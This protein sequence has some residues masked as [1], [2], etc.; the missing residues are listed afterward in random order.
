MK[1]A[2]HDS[3]GLDNR[4]QVNLTKS[5]LR[6]NETFTHTTFIQPLLDQQRTA[7]LT[8]LRNGL[9]TAGVAATALFGGVAPALAADVDFTFEMPATGTAP[10]DAND[11]P[12]NDSSQTNN[13]VRTLD[14]ITYRWK[15]TVNNGSSDNS[16][17]TTTL[18][19]NQAFEQIPAACQPGSVSTDPVSNQQTLTCNLGDIASGTTGFIDFQVKVLTQ[20]LDGTSYV[21]NGDTTSA[22][23]TF[24]SDTAAPATDG[25]LSAIV[26]AAP[27]VDLLKNAAWVSGTKIDPATG[28]NGAIVRYPISM[29]ISN[30]GKGSEALLSPISFIDDL[31]QHVPGTK[32]YDWGNHS[33]CGPLGKPMFYG[34]RPY[35]VNDGTYLPERSVQDSGT[36]NCTQAAAGSN[37]NVSISGADTTGNHAP[38][39]SYNNVT[40]PASQTWLVSGFMELWMPTQAIIDAGGSIGVTNTVTALN[41]TGVSGNPNQEPTLANNSY[42]HTVLAG[43]GSFNQYYALRYQNRGTV[44]PGMSTLNGGDGPVMATQ[45]FAKRLYGFNRGLLAWDDYMYCEKFDNETHKLVDI[46][47]QAG[48]AV[49]VYNNIAYDYVIEYGTGGYIDETDQ[50]TTTC[51]D[52]ESPAGWFD[53]L[54]NV[55][56]GRDA[57][58]KIR[59]RAL[60]PVPPN[61]TM[62][63]AVNFESRNNFLTSGTPIPVGTILS[64]HSAIRTPTLYSNTT[65]FPGNWNRGTYN[66]AT[67]GGSKS[68]GDRLTF[69][70][71]IVRIDKTTVP[72]DEVN[73]ILAGGTVTYQLQP[74]VTAVINPAPVNPVV[75]VT[76]ILPAG[77]IYVVGSASLPPT[78]ITSNSDGTTTIEWNLGPQVPGQVVTP[79]T[80]DAQVSPI[81]SNNT[82]LVNEVIVSSPE[83]PSPESA[84][85]DDRTVTVGNPG[86]YGLSKDTS[87]PLISLNNQ[88]TFRLFMANLSAVDLEAA[89]FIDILPYNGDGTQ[90]PDGR[91]PPSDFS[92]TATFSSISGSNGETF[93]FT[94]A[95]QNTI[96]PDPANNTNVWCPQT[97]FGTAGCPANN[98]DVTA[99]KIAAPAFPSNTPTRQVDLVLDTS[100]NEPGEVYTNDATGRPNN[101]GFIIS[102]DAIVRTLPR[103]VDIE[104]DKSVSDADGIVEVGDTI[105]YTLN[106]VNKGPDDARFVEVTDAL[107]AGL[108]YVSDDSGGAFDTSTGLWTI[109]PMAPNGVAQ[110]N[111]TMTVTGTGTITNTAEVTR[112]DDSADPSLTNDVDSTPSNGNAAEDD[113]DFITI[114]STTPEI[115]VAKN[116]ASVSGR[117]V[118]FDFVVENLGS[119]PLSNVSLTDNLDATFGAGN[120]SVTAPTIQVAPSA[121]STVTAN[122][123][124]NGTTDIN[125]IDP[126]NSALVAGETVTVRV[127]V[128]VNTFVDP[129]GSGPLGFA[130]YE[131]QANTAGTSPGGTTVTDESDDGTDPD[132][133]GD[134][135]PGG[136][137]ETDS[138]EDDP[139]PVDFMIMPE[140][141]TAKT[142][143]SN[144]NNDNGTYTVTYDIVVENLGNIVLQNVQLAEDLATTFAAATGFTVNSLTVTNGSVTANPSFD[145]S[146]N[147]SLLVGNDSLA[148]GATATLQLAVIVTPGS[149]DGP[150]NNQVVATGTGDSI[151]VTDDSDDGT[152]PDPDGDGNPGGPDETDSPEDDPTP[153]SFTENPE[154]GT[155]K[156]VT[157]VQNNAD[158]S[159]TVTYAIAVE[160]LGDVSLSNVQ[161]AEDFNATFGAAASFS[162]V[163]NSLSITS[164][165]VTPS[166]TFNGT[167]D[168]GLLAGTDTMASGDVAT[169]ELQVTV[170]PANVSDTYNNTVV[171]TGD[172]PRGDGVTDNSD[173]GTDPDPD[174]DGNP[175]GPDET[176]SPEDDPTPV[177]FSE[178]PE[179]GTAKRISNAVNNQ[180]G[181]YEITYSIVV[182]NLGDVNLN[183]VQLTEDL[184]TTFAG[185]TA[186]TVDSFSLVSG[187]VTPNT[188]FDGSASQTLLSGSDTL[189]VG[190]TA[191]LQLVV[192]LTPGVNSATY[193]NTVVADATSPG[194]DSVTDDSDDGTDPDPDG[195]GN[196]GGPDET[197]SPEDDPTPFSINETP[198]IGV[199]KNVSNVTNNG[200]GSYEIS[201]AIAL[202][203]L[204]DVNLSNVQLTED[205][206]ATFGAATSFSFN[207]LSVTSG[208]VTANSAFNGT[209]DTNLLIG[210]E[211]LNV[212][213][214]AILELVVTVVPANITDS[215]LNTVVASGTPPSGTPV[216]D[217]S[218]DGT[219]PDPDGDGNP[220]GP[221]ETDSPEDDP[222]PVS[223]TEDPEIGVAKRVTNSVNNLDG[224]YAVTY[225]VV[226]ENLGDVNLNNIQLT[227]DLGSTFASATGFTVD[228]LTAVNGGITAN[229][230]FDGS[231]DQNLLGGSDALAI[232]NTAEL[233]LVVTVTPGV[234]SATYNNTVV[235]DG[236]SPG[237]TGV[238]DDSDDGTDPDPDG[239]GNPGGPDETDSSE[240]DPTPVSFSEDPEIGTAKR[241]TNTVNN[242]DGTYQITY[243]IVVENLGDV[244][245]NNVQLTEDLST[246]FAGA[247]GFTVDSLSLLNGSVTPNGSFDGSA[248]STLLSGSDSLA[249][250]GTAELQL[251]VTVTPGTASATYENT[252]VADGTS[253][254]GTG[255]TDDSDDGTDPDPDGDGNPGG[256]DE[257]DSPEDDPTTVSIAEDPEM[258][259]AKRVTNQVNNGDG[260]YAITYRIVVEN[261]GD[262]NLS[263]VQL[264]EN[265][266]M[267]FVGATGFTVD[268][269]SVVSGSVT[270]NGAFDGNG[271]TNLLGGSD[272]LAVGTMA[273]LELAVTVTPG[274]GSATYSNTVVGNSTSPAGDPVTDD[275]DDGTDP[276]PDGDGNPGGPD[277]TDSSEDDPTVVSLTE[278]PEIG[279]AKQVVT[280]QS[281]G[282]GTYTVTYDIVVENLGDVTLNNVQLTEALATTFATATGFTVDSL[283]V[284]AGNVTANPSFDGD[285]DA[286]LLASGTSLLQAETATLQ[287]VVT[288][289]PGAD[290]GPYS[291]TVV[292]NGTSPGGDPVTDDSDDGTDPDPDGDGNPGG[293]DET[294]SSEDDPT[295]V[296]FAETPLI[297]TAKQVAGIQNNGDG[298][299]T[300]TYDIVVENMG[301]VSLANVQLT[302][303]LSATFTG[304]TSFTFD[305]LTV[306]SGAVTTNSAYDGSSNTGLLT[307]TETLAAAETATLQLVVTVVPATLTDTYSNTV[308]A[309]GDSPAGTLVTDSS[310]DG[311]DPDPDDDGLPSGPD[312]NDPSETEDDPTPVMFAELPE[313]GVAKQVNTVVNNGDGSYNVT[314]DIVVENLGDVDVANLQLTDDLTTTFAGTASFNFDSLTVTSGSVTLSPSYD[315][316][317]DTAMLAGSDVLPVGETAEL[318]LVVVVTPGSNLGPYNNQILGEGNSPGGSPVSDLSDDGAEPDADG[319]GNAGGADETDSE[320]D[321]PTP[322]EFTENPVIGT[323]KA[324]ASS[325]SNGDGTYSVTYDI[326]TE[327][328][329]DVD[330]ANVQITENLAATFAGAQAFA[331]QSTTVTS[332]PVTVNPSFDGNIDTNLLA[333]IDSMAVGESA[334]L[335]MVVLV[336]PGS[337]LGPYDNSITTSGVSPA[338]T[339]VEDLSDDGTD[340]SD[341]DGD[342]NPTGD[343][344]DDPTRISFDSYPRM[345]LLKRITQVLS[346]DGTRTFSDPVIDGPEAEALQ[347]AGL[348]PVGTPEITTL[349]PVR[350][351]DILEY[352]IYYLS[353][354]NVAAG[355]VNLCDLVP[356]DTTFLVDS[357][358]ASQGIS[359]LLP[360]AAATQLQSNAADGDVGT[361]YSPLAPLP[362]GNVCSDPANPNGA[363]LVDL[364]TVPSTPGNNAGF[365]RFRVRVN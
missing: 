245:L 170:V 89:E 8:S 308:V 47:G 137:D 104:L 243:S 300:V 122:A 139:T 114:T 269:L 21:G 172:S 34:S 334:S 178:N 54:N 227:E 166:N 330:L 73:T 266:A 72:N 212:S 13:V 176:D 24:S 121:G 168:T 239:D 183:N 247:T 126:S 95:P 338:G 223:F 279:T 46:P 326:M 130:E 152:D 364:Q 26:S 204:G 42:S 14:L 322:V 23:A 342:G 32:L 268:S 294:D 165:P 92:G 68:L 195:D 124:F 343:G 33:G 256:P 248:N 301:D 233:E 40:L 150:Y 96:A 213:G 244:N 353:D 282:D 48:E 257:T 3:K 69:V 318:Q 142:V 82:D 259:T 61:A 211:T 324:I 332:G 348:N 188:G 41:G 90:A 58:T 88:M 293:P 191:E 258:G 10:F 228:S 203:N 12:G 128:T 154:I 116:A 262:V 255:V 43:S 246:T 357:F 53:N 167:T 345:R 208:P 163:A 325:I 205:L 133:D 30:G 186:F 234:A 214:T 320:E 146:G 267:T 209:T 336:T 263:N 295:P 153:V 229:A 182:E 83:D 323:A 321:D 199:A 179:I 274:V 335:Q 74:T 101:L 93:T 291:N 125:L 103:Q 237:G 298:S 202:E 112:D 270:A 206:N 132:P 31:S 201:Y 276:D 171:A 216:A 87:T 162:Y 254:G 217:D 189:A 302:E 226:V 358:G 94:N 39:K 265:L 355:P 327:N 340:P 108:A 145:G 36:W 177:S 131:N 80:F 59:F 151:P 109:G 1:S 350:S 356:T 155:A 200:D 232:G 51:E 219:D 49:A 285:G 52:A 284:T 225:S 242:Q 6:S 129:D 135:N 158:G 157:N 313:L 337:N 292:A 45:N 286:N 264:T 193:N 249:V 136:P 22:T 311:T 97:A 174:G 127:V 231:G 253:P 138:P 111:I 105:V 194:G 147:T 100:G 278:T 289:T 71:G 303:D 351:G 307:G 288:I 81:V 184:A 309:S 29:V 15:Y 315:G 169:L 235:A 16:I 196:P 275:S 310:D 187:S 331:V 79:I 35:G 210:T 250:G 99:V 78:S 70:R 115:G 55:P 314:Y 341:Q 306:T 328:L 134:G 305:S 365:V 359:V 11:N 113:Q 19:P 296:E 57:V 230:G 220:G 62:D 65:S 173:D 272:A 120:Y 2:S 261:L 76:D 290:L 143:V 50:R 221:D 271:D 197:D 77:M 185:A 344:E 352:T 123:G 149:N 37:I 339:G 118:T 18:S 251:V 361:F 25:P 360:G 164:G 362:A 117:D 222:T 98:A 224:T 107:P 106:V 84:R 140:I 297:G 273:E 20:E 44:M 119:T 144:V 75:T 218:D 329:G 304:A 67:H 349:D 180:D 38:T 252:V 60:E 56:G 316:S 241:V 238:T 346:K 181:T 9:L 363:V 192:T 175:G 299:Y 17:F 312:E 63:L 5:G 277:E 260:T 7:W 156:Q 161:L 319:D 86:A 110:L 160:N 4:S 317:T 102:P 240:D 85:D 347:A 148:V 64:N 28:E 66:S 281:N 280:N 198:E 283:N 207:S 215:Y 287:L 91:T 354:G 141:G 159:Y 333:G 236:T 190:G 27:K